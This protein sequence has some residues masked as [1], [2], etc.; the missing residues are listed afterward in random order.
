MNQFGFEEAHWESAKAEAKLVLSDC[1]KRRQMIPYSEFVGRVRSISLQAHDPRLAHF[2]EEI[3]TEE[4]AA[5]RGMLTALVV[6][7]HGDQRPGPGFFDL[8]NRLGRNTDDID[9]CWI[10][11]VSRVFSAWTT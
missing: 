2:L 8:A 9:K 5:G 6:H 7:K 10:E 1:A 11:E 3:S 4:H